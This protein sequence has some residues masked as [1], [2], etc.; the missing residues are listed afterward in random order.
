MGKTSD[1]RLD[2]QVLLVFKDSLR[3]KGRWLVHRRPKLEVRIHRR[4]IDAPK[5][6]DDFLPTPSLSSEDEGFE[7]AARGGVQGD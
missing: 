4:M 5:L 6:G 2:I 7:K 3:W 1:I